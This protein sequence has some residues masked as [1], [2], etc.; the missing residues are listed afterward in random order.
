MQRKNLYITSDKI[1]EI[2]EAYFDLDG[3]G[4]L[5]FDEVFQVQ[6]YLGYNL[7]YAE[8]EKIFQ[9]ADDDDSKTIDF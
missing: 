6:H 2:Q 9:E 1:N 3:N 4:V 7:T 8:T 5:T